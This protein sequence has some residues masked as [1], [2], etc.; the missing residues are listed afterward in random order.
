MSPTFVTGASGLLGRALVEALVARGEEVVVLVRD[1]AAAAAV[2]RRVRV[3]VGDVTD[4]ALLAEAVRGADTVFHLAARATDGADP[5]AIYA[6][7]IAGTTAVLDAAR[8]NDVG[9]TVVASSA[10]VYG[11]SATA[12]YAEDMEPAPVDPYAIS[13]AAADLAARAQFRAHGLPVATARLT[14]VYG[15]VDRNASRLIP[16]LIS[17]ALDGRAPVLRSDGTP[18]RDFVHLD[19][20]VAALLAIAGAMPAGQAFNVGLGRPAAVREV[21]QTLEDVLQQPLRAEYAVAPSPPSVAYVSTAK[22][23]ALTGWT[24]RIDL[25]EGLARTV[26]AYRDDRLRLAA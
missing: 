11:P 4:H 22:L 25:R 5:A 14:N 10:A 23:T 13:K 15:A 2:D 3:V 16:E 17:A 8:S 6:T 21:V 1:P 12:P 20:A 26:A 9:R 7:N 18:Q 24:A 19:D